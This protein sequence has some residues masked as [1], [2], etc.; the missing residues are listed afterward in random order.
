MAVTGVGLE[1]VG[2]T[3]SYDFANSLLGLVE[4]F[5]Y[6]IRSIWCGIG[7]GKGAGGT[8]G[9]WSRVLEVEEG[10]WI[11]CEG[12]GYTHGGGF[13]NVNVVASV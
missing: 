12:I 11:L 7:A 2:F 13:Y 6:H 1:Q 5:P 9:R 8:R 3:G 4:P 10:V